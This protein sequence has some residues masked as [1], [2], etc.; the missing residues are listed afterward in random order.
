M[1]SL[2]FFAIA[3]LLPA[4]TDWPVYGHDPGG[5][6]YSPLTQINPANVT[7]LERA[8]SFHHGKP[9]SQ[10]TPLVVSSRK[11]QKAGVLSCCCEAGRARRAKA[12]TRASSSS[13][14][15]G[16]GK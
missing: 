10:V 16:L 1:R 2:L 6:R 4:Q 8:W 9:G 12:R 5:M 7:R 14:S 3:A 11:P 13:R 15:N